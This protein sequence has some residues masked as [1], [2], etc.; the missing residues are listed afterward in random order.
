MRSLFFRGEEASYT[1]MSIIGN[2][3]VVLVMLLWSQ[4]SQADECQRY[5]AD[6]TRLARQT[7]GLDA[8]VPV[9]AAQLKQE[10]GCNPLAVS[11]VGAQGMAQF[12]PATAKWWCEIN[13]IPASAC[14][15]TSPSWA[16]RAMVGYDQWLWNRVS[17]VDACNR[18][19]MT[20]SAYNGGIGWVYRDQAAAAALQAVKGRWWGHVERYNAGRSA[21]SFAENRGYP[22][23]ILL[24]LQPQYYAWGDGLCLEIPR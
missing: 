7:W 18:M 2:V 8:P 14:A 17:A 22:R 11:R 23:R 1:E 24:T 20:L 12:M 5:R 9:F 21:A 6:L 19:A 10:S 16:I 13:Q 4:F 3:L 15:P